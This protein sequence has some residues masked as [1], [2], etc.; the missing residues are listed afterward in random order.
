MVRTAMFHALAMFHMSANVPC[1]VGCSTHRLVSHGDA[2]SRGRHRPGDF[3]N[4]NSP[5]NPSDLSKL[6]SRGDFSSP[7]SLSLSGNS[8]LSNN[9]S[10]SNRGPNP[11]SR[12]SPSSHSDYSSEASSFIPSSIRDLSRNEKLSLIVLRWLPSG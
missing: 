8:N 4:P 7:N 11:S 1:F 5:S 9:L 3:I 12:S 10:L 2:P 6:G